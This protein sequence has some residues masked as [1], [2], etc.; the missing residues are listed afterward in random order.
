MLGNILYIHI[1]KSQLTIVAI[2]VHYNWVEHSAKGAAANI[3]WFNVGIKL[4]FMLRFMH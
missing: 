1:W 3:C 4:L 2:A